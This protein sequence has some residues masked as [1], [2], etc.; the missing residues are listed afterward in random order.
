MS[1]AARMKAVRTT[2][3]PP[4]GVPSETAPGVEKR[5]L[6]TNRVVLNAAILSRILRIAIDVTG[7]IGRVSVV[8]IARTHL[9]PANVFARLAGTVSSLIPFACVIRNALPVEVP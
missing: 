5:W 9:I 2:M 6:T 1:S 8:N 3:D 4:A 7:R